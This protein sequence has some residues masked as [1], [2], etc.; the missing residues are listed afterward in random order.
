MRKRALLRG[1]TYVLNFT[2]TYG[3]RA[4]DALLPHSSSMFSK[5]SINLLVLN[6]AINVGT[7]L[8]WVLRTRR[9]SK[10]VAQSQNMHTV[11]QLIIDRYFDLELLDDETTLDAHRQTALAIASLEQHMLHVSRLEAQACKLDEQ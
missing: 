4:I 5:V 11:E 2:I 9:L 10:E 7:Y 6:G 1:F 8:V 3:A